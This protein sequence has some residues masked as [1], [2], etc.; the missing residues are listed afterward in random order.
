MK[1]SKSA[2]KLA[3]LIHAAIEDHKITNSEY[4]EI[5]HTA[6]ED[7]I[8]DPEERAL[9]AQLQEMIADKTVARVAG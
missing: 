9:L 7:G 5:L 4:E 2:R 6:H 8:I 3:D 1:P